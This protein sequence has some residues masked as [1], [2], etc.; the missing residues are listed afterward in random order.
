MGSHWIFEF[1]ST[2]SNAIE[3]QFTGFNVIERNSSNVIEKDNPIEFTVVCNGIPMNSLL[4]S[5]ISSVNSM[6]LSRIPLNCCIDFNSIQYHWKEICNWME[7]HKIIQC[8][9]EESHQWIQCYW[10]ESNWIIALASTQFNIF[11]RKY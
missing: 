3:R 4:L 8:N 1:N 5:G 11:E 2:L 9:W 6:L 10:V 7:S